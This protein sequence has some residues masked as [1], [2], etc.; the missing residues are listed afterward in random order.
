MGYVNERLNFNS[1]QGGGE[2]W[3][4]QWRSL[5]STWYKPR[6]NVNIDFKLVKE[7]PSDLEILQDAGGGD[8][9][10]GCPISSRRQGRG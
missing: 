4:N 10:L 2:A 8:A 3:S 7:N 9:T 1:E 5:L 6:L